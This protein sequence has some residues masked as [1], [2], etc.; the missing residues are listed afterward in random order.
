MSGPD[1]RD[2]VCRRTAQPA[3][4]PSLSAGLNGLRIAR[5]GGYFERLLSD[6]ARHS[7]DRV[8]AQLDVKASIDLPETARA[9]AAAFLITMAESAALHLERLKTRAQDFDPEVRDRLLAGA[10]LPASFV[11]KAQVFRRWYHAQCLA[12]F[13]E[14]DVLVAPATPTTAPH[15]DQ[16]VLNLDGQTL[17]VR[18]NIGIHTQP[19]SFVGLPVVCVPTWTQGALPIGVQLIAAPGREDHAL[20]VAQVLEE[21]RVARA[22]VATQTH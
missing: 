13:A 8:C 12:A 10:M 21:T 4:T 16:T 3:L 15:L 9:R 18:A 20:R 19:I 22:P 1:G 14:V 5:A 11:Q 6:D 2:P 7:V 17:P